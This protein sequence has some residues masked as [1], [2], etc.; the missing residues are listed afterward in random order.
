MKKSAVKLERAARRRSL[1]QAIDLQWSSL[2]SHLADAAQIRG[3]AGCAN[4]RWHAQCVRE[5]AFAIHA[6]SVELHELAKFDF[7]EDF[8]TLS[9]PI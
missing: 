8:S 2:R 5:Y 6:M 1:A 3:G 7:K 4:E 9:E